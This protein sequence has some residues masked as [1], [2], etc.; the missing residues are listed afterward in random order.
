MPTL[1]FVTVTMLVASIAVT[2]I[3]LLPDHSLGPLQPAEIG[4]V[5]VF[6]IGATGGQTLVAW[7]R[8]RVDVASYFTGPG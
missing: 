7:A 6:V 1:E 8:P 3:A 5:L 2:P 4:W